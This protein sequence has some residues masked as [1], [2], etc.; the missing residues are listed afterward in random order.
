M[1]AYQNIH[2]FPG[3]M[4]VA[5][6]EIKKLLPQIDLVIEIGDARAPLSSFNNLIE[7]VVEGKRLLEFIQKRIYAI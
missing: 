2:W 3:H 7:K 1:A 6:D 5:F 4:K